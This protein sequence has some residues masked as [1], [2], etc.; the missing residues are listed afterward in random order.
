MFRR[1]L[2]LAAGAPV[3]AISACKKPAPLGAHLRPVA[4][5]PLS[6]SGFPPKEEAAT[7]PEP[8]A[9]RPA[10]AA[11]ISADAIL[12]AYR[13]KPSASDRLEL[14]AQLHFAAPAQAVSVV[15]QLLA[16]EKDVDLRVQLLDTL[17]VFEG[18][19]PAKLEL[20]AGLV[21]E[22][23]LVEDVRE[24]ALDALQNIQDGRAIS[25]WE[26]LL[27]DPDE[28]TRTLAREMIALLRPSDSP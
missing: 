4:E 11:P 9:A 17:D 22:R 14:I 27:V 6:E 5:P 1:L 28:E 13:A 8:K 16:F 20:L 18:E 12:R 10:A 15:G 26:K 3:L 21:A 25:V 19:T 2:W 24:A 7:A 23:G